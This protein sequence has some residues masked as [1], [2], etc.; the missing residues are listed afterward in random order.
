MVKTN[1]NVKRVCSFYGSDWHLI[2]M[3]LPHLNKELNKQITVKTILETNV[4]NKVEI[5]LSKINLKDEDR[6]NI[7]NIGWEEKT[8]INEDLIKNLLAENNKEIEII[9]NGNNNYIES[10]N[11]KIEEYI[12]NNEVRDKKITIINCYYIDDENV[13]TNIKEILAKNDSVLKTLGEVPA[14]EYLK[15]A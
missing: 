2:T 11:K 10:A 7:L 5:L 3:I 6:N 15:K 13:N 14:D 9:I 1:Y 8:N 12:Q 4:K